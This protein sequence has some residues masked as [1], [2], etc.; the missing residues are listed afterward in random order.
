MN[1][2]ILAI[3]FMVLFT[4]ETLYVVWSFWY[5]TKE[6]QRT[7]ECYYD[8]CSENYDA[9]YDGEVCT[10]Y[11]LDVFGEYSIAKTEYMD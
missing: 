8:I 11:D 4:L 7:Y 3:V 2:K 1:W 5:Y 6:E 9:H 10:C